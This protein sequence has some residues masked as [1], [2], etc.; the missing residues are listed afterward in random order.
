MIPSNYP[1]WVERIVH[2]ND[3][4]EEGDSPVVTLPI[5]SYQFP[6][7]S[8]GR[9]GIDRD[10]SPSR[11]PVRID[12]ETTTVLPV[13]EERELRGR[14]R[15]LG[16]D[17]TFTAHLSAEGVLTS[18]PEGT[19]PALPPR[20]RR[21][22]VTGGNSAIWEMGMSLE[23]MVRARIS[24]INLSVGAEV[25]ATSAGALDPVSVEQVVTEIHLGREGEDRSVIRRAIEACLKPETFDRVEI[26]RYLTQRMKA[27]TVERVRDAL[28]DPRIG[29]KVRA[30]Y[31]EENP[32]TLDELLQAYRKKYPN[33]S[34][35]KQVAIAALGTGIM[36]SVT[37]LSLDEEYVGDTRYALTDDGKIVSVQ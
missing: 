4:Q 2:A 29:F 3:A 36:P 35:G 1:T 10:G 7:I 33:D 12:W 23:R 6:R 16:W 17:E 26:T 28:G 13:G 14:L 11:L 37:A 25:C 34:L 22:V 19:P 15:S 27:R 5:W 8:V 9:K 21:A 32:R 20:T 30:V 31:R 24:E 18:L